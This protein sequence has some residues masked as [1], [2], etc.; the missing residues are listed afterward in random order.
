MM[1]KLFLLLFLLLLLLLLQHVLQIQELD[2]HMTV[3][4]TVM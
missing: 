2:R 1:C 3:S 4:P